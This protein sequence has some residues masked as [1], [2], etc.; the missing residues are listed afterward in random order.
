MVKHQSVTYVSDCRF[1]CTMIAAKRILYK[2]T[3]I[4][5]NT[6][7]DIKVLHLSIKLYLYTLS[8]YT[9]GTSNQ[10]TTNYITT[11]IRNIPTYLVVWLQRPDVDFGDQFGGK[12]DNKIKDE[13]KICEH[14]I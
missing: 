9:S 8:G 7:K 13:I 2:M 11:W 5:T 6:Q 1:Y 12:T 10:E 4:C 3:K 14:T